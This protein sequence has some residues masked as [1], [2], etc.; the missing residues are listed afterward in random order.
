MHRIAT[1]P[2]SGPPDSGDLVEQPPAKVLLLTSALSDISSLAATLRIPTIHQLWRDGIRALPLS[3]LSHPAQVDHYLSTT[4][5]YADVVIIRLLG[6]RSHWNYGLEQVRRWQ[7]DVSSRVLVVLAGTPDQDK[8]LHDLGSIDPG[9][10]DRLAELMRIGGTNNLVKFLEVVGQLQS[11]A[12]PLAAKITPQ[13]MADPQP[14]DWQQEPGPRVG[15]IL[16]RA[17]YSHSLLC[18]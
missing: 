15:V 1:L 17:L 14:W 5:Q 11:G 9:L 3:A 10:A 16:Y 7:E 18:F 13:P 2:G 6:G 8:E 4:A 12:R